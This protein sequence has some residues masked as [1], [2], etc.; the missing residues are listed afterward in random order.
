MANEIYQLPGTTITFKASGGDV[1]FTPTSVSNGAGRISA[2]Y[3][4]G[5]GAKPGLYRWEAITK[6]AAGLAVGAALEI[7]LA[8]AHVSSSQ[9]DG[10]QSTSDA[11]FSATDKRRN[12]QYVGSVVADSTSSGE[13]QTASG[14]VFITA[15][16]ISVVWWNAFG[17]ALSST[18][19]DHVFT[20]T[21]YAPQIQ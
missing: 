18:A 17:Q 11:A 4:R 7:S 2:Q 1:T 8:T 3:D 20:L 19:G 9:I 14:L 15:R 10:N 12:L 5:S 16:Y 13:I 6:A 21:P